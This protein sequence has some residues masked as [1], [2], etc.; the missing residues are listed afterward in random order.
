MVDMQVPGGGRKDGKLCLAPD[1]VNAG[2]LFLEPP[3]GASRQ[4][5]AIVIGEAV[6]G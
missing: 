6:G 2:L 1:S 4:S 3:A 5:I